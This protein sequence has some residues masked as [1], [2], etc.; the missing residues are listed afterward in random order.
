M[1]RRRSRSFGTAGYFVLLSLWTE[2]ELGRRWLAT[3]L[4][5][6]R[7]RHWVQVKVTWRHRR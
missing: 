7:P 1:S 5:L 4:H 2:P 6:G 3:S